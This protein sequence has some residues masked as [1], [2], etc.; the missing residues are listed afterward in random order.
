MGR[1]CCFSCI[2]LGM[3]KLLD[4]VVEYGVYF[5]VG[6]TPILYF[7]GSR[8][9]PYVTSKT[10]FFYGCMGL[11]FFIWS[12]LAI[13]DKSYRLSK[14]ILLFFLPIFLFVL[15]MTVTSVLGVDPGLSFW[16][17]LGRATGMLTLYYCLSLSVVIASFVQLKGDLYIRKL[18]TCFLIGAFV[19]SLSVWLSDEGFNL[20]IKVL[21]NSKGGGLIGNSSITAAYLVFAL[22]FGIFMLGF[23]NLIWKQKIFLWSLIFLIISSPLFFNVY[24]VLF[25][26]RFFVSA[27]GAMLGIFA[28]FFMAI[29]GYLFLSNNKKIRILGISGIILSVLVSSVLW[30]N[31]LKSDTSIHKKV[32]DSISESRFIFWDI[33]EKAIKEKPI[34][35]WGPDNYP[36]VYQKYFDPNLYLQSDTTV[37]IWNDRAHNVIFD[38]GVSGGYPAIILYLGV[39][40]SLVLGIYRAFILRG[41]TRFQASVLLG[42]VVAYFFQNLFVFDSQMSLMVYF[43]FIGSV[44]GIKESAGFGEKKDYILNVNKTRKLFFMILLASLFTV[45]WIMFVWMPSRKVVLIARVTS[46]PMNKRPDH[47]KDL[48]NGSKIGDDRDIGAIA[49]AGYLVYKNNQEQLRLDNEKFIYAKKDLEKFLEY[50]EEIAKK[51]PNDYRLHLSIARIYNIYISLFDKQGDVSLVQHVLDVENHIKDI[52]PN[53]PEVYWTI[54]QSLIFSG[55]SVGAQEALEY[56]IKIAPRIP[57][58]YQLLMNFA[59]GTGNM[60]LYN[61]TLKSAQNE[62]PGY[63]R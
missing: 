50:L 33:A 58:S 15:W 49:H 8:Y 42:L 3:K 53:N 5:V 25:G 20:S 30:I 29:L 57:G 4:L 19:V 31:L 32:A 55:D 14:R 13:I 24:G 11:V 52:S 40:V 18:F 22:F 63:I 2:I 6:V 47:Y 41:I 34:L 39:L 1:F 7:G 48:L 28:G 17:S 26:G 35:G 46:M 12:Y 43:I 51:E 23:K 16:S 21:E 62:I 36:V 60:E 9:A 44:F 54:A 61:R 45:S 59:E 56:A 38:T 27:R 37:E 10:F